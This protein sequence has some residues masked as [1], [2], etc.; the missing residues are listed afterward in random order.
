MKRCFA[1][2]MM[3]LLVGQAS[4]ALGT[5]MTHPINWASGIEGSTH[6]EWY[7]GPNNM[8]G[9]PLAP[10]PIVADVDEND[11]GI[12]TMEIFPVI[13]PLNPTMSGWQ[14]EKWGRD[15]VWPLSGTAEATIPNTDEPNPWKWI[16]VQIVWAPEETVGIGEHPCVYGYLFDALGEVNYDSGIEASELAKEPLELVDPCA[17]EGDPLFGYQ[18]YR[19]TYLIVIEPNPDKELVHIGGSIYIDEVIID[20]L[21]FP[22]PATMSLLVMG[23]SVLLLRQRRKIRQR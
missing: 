12:P 8:G 7:F 11:Y 14:S 20:T 15:G 9:D 18:W 2:L 22:E 10:S 4:I 6:Q 1:L 21:C 17:E 3:V 19:S 5:A 13:D 23:G 16:E